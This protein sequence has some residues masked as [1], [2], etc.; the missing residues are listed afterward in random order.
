MQNINKRI[1]ILHETE[2]HIP[3]E[4]ELNVFIVQQSYRE[5]TVIKQHLKKKE[6]GET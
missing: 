5:L 6:S 2:P 3:S 1:Y 4:I